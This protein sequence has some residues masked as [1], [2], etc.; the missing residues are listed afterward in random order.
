MSRLI[1]EQRHCASLVY[2]HQRRQLNLSKCFLCR[3]HHH[4]TRVAL[5]WE[6][7]PVLAWVH[8]REKNT[9]Y[10][11]SPISCHHRTSCSESL[12]E[13]LVFD[14]VDQ[15]TGVLGAQPS[16]L[17]KVESYAA[18][19]A[20]ISQVSNPLWVCWSSVRP[21]LPTANQ[22]TNSAQR[23]PRAILETCWKLTLKSFAIEASLSPIALRFRICLAC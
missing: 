1:L 7:V 23:V 2:L 19:L 13:V 22:P 18:V 9:R 6:I 11:L 10:L 8:C 20:L 4:H 14:A 3:V 21:G 16:P 12:W 15:T 5:N 17:L